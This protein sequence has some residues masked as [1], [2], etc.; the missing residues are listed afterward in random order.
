MLK[1]PNGQLMPVQIPA[2]M[3]GGS[4]VQV[5]TQQTT[6]AADLKNQVPRASGSASS[7][8]QGGSGVASASTKQ[9]CD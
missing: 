3:V 5:A 8:I 1:M 9:V 2:A 7:G 4:S 6:S